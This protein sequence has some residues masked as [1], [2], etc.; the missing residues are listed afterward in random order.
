MEVRLDREGAT[1]KCDGKHGETRNEMET[2]RCM[3]SRAREVN[4]FERHFKL[5]NR[6]IHLQVAAPPR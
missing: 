1:A 4:C 6:F 5:A 2:H 3:G